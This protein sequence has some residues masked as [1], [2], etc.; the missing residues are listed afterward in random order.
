M[1]N[2]QYKINNKMLL[3][4]FISEKLA[5]SLQYEKGITWIDGSL[6]RYHR[7]QRGQRT[8][9]RADASE[10]SAVVIENIERTRTTGIGSNA[11]DNLPLCESV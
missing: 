7:D 5:L 2:P 6:G 10:D 9:R 8:A 1:N 4:I 11:G 3:F